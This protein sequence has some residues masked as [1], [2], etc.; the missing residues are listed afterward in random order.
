MEKKILVVD[1]EKNF[2]WIFKQS[3]SSAGF[4]V[5]TAEN[6]ES[7]IQIAQKENPDMILLD[8]MMPG[9]DGIETAKKIKELG[10]KCP[11][12]FLTNLKD[13]E[14]ISQAMELGTSE[15]IVKSDRHIDD[16]VAAIKAKLDQ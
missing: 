12:M 14:H 3:L 7:A 16:I 11:I 6:G 13:E 15:Y 1:D 8:I 2:L 4:V 10:I 9:I 5:F